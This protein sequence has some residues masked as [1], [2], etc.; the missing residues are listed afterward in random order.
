MRATIASLSL[1]FANTCFAQEQVKHIG[2][3]VEPYYRAAEE[4]AG[5]PQVAV[6]QAFDAR[7]R[8]NEPKKIKEVE[9]EIRANPGLITPMTLM[10]LSIRLYDMGFRE[11]SVF[12]HYVA[13]DRMFTISRVVSTS[14]I[15]GA[16]IATRDFAATAGQVINGYAFC[17]PEAQRQL[18][19]R[20]F[21][22]VRDNPYQAIFFPQLA[23]PFSDREAALNE[24]INALE[25][26]V[27][28][29]AEFLADNS[30]IERLKKVRSENGA[31]AKYCW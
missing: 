7:L 2:V 29:E 22:W 20:A 16:M 8:L 12:W 24:A 3:F 18:R 14:G 13:K 10:V 17:N 25:D 15:S 19:K 31:H 5:T 1:L 28:K 11:D 4:A 6:A 27:R 26:I 21:E 23:S 9:A 30:N